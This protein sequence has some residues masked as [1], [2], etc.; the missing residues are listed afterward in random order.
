MSKKISKK[1]LDEI[2]KQVMDETTENFAKDLEDAV[3]PKRSMPLQEI[4]DDLIPKLLS[5]TLVNAR[6]HTAFVIQDVLERLDL[7]TDDE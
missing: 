4:V 3:G 5:V 1:E 6:S 2:I 7:L